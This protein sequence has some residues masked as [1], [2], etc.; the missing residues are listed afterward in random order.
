MRKILERYTSDSC[1]TSRERR[2]TAGG[3]IWTGVHL[4]TT[5]DTACFTADKEGVL[6]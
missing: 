6:V 3:M 5:I 2:G 4:L 1:V